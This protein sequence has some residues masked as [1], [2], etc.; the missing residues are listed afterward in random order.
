MSFFG[1][2]IKRMLEVIKESGEQSM[3]YSKDGFNP[4]KIRGL[5]LLSLVSVGKFPLTPAGKQSD[6]II[7]Y[8]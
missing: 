8:L 2:H 1:V 5:I 7:L 6:P 3:C 4:L